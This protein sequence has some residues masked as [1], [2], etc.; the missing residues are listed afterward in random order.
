ME[1]KR[2]NSIDLSSLYDY[3]SYI[4]KKEPI[5]S[6]KYL[7]FWISKNKNELSNCHIIVDEEKK[8]HGQILASSMSY[9]YNKKKID[10]VWLFDLIIDENLRK[11]AWGID[12]L[13]TCMETHPKSC[14]TGSGPTALPIHLKLG[15]SFLGEIRKYVGIVFPQ[16]FITSF[17][18][19]T[20]PIALFPQKVVCDNYIFKLISRE[21]LPDFSM[22]FNENLFEITREKDFLKWRFF[23]SFH[24]YALYYNI[25]QQIYFVLRSIIIKGFRVMELVDYRC[26]I[27]DS[28]IEIIYQAVKKVTKKLRLP[29]IVWGSSLAVVDK[30]LERHHFKS[31]GRPR[32]VLGF[33]KCK[34]RL[35]DIENRNF[36]L[37]TLAD[38][39]GETNWI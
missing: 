31:I 29:V 9:F 16:Y 14:S 18:R 28:N 12:L 33:L 13:L 4:Y 27:S 24:K 2:V 7:D 32:P 23:N 38:S 1:I 17:K 39:D 15:N 34:D 5:D 10:T 22:P 36:A 21:E 35:K 20:I 19:P 25:E 37:V 8:I 30:S 3:Y 11:E 6:K 26:N